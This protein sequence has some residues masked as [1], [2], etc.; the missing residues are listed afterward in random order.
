MSK[1]LPKGWAKAELGKVVSSQKGKK[2]KVLKTEP[3]KGAVPYLDIKAF[4]KNEV[5]KYAEVS[6]SRIIDESAVAMVW[7]GARSGWTA[8]GKYGALGSTLAAITPII[9]DVDYLFY[10]L[11]SQYEYINNNQRG[12][13]IPH[14]DPDKLW[15]LQFPLAPL[16]EQ[17]RI[18]DKLDA[19]FGHMDNINKGLERIPDLLKKFR[20]QV[21]TQAV[22]GKLTEDWRVENSGI[23]HVQHLISETNTKRANHYA[24]LVADAKRNKEKKP[25]KPSNLE[26]VKSLIDSPSIRIEDTTNEWGIVS[27]AWVSDNLPD[28]IVD[29]PF[30]SSINVKDDYIG[31]G[32][33]VVRMVNIRPFRFVKEQLRFIRLQ[34][35]LELRRHNILPTDVLLAKVGAT[36]GDCCIYPDQEPE[37][38]LSTTG[39]CRVRLDKNVMLPDFLQLYLSSK[40]YSLKIISSQTAQ[41]F[42]NMKTLK[43]FPVV[44]PFIEE[45]KEIVKRVDALFKVADIIEQQYQALHKKAEQLPQ[46]ILSKAFRGELVPQ[47]PDDEPATE[48]LKQ[49]E[50]MK[51]KSK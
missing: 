40:A 21:L 8:K 48:L 22:T 27:L 19:L 44:L 23:K 1:Q 15:S 6:T 9:G 4:E 50:T 30:G 51:N 14:V 28:S 11:Q 35:F 31:E 42:L 41:P 2:P 17:K 24:Q 47:Y 36:I 12:I 46:A 16:A 13:G 39:S 5:S 29:G 18:A 45:Q 43:A 7:D 26:D 20:Q 38:M 3:F 37:A 34:K 49:I 25:K 10:Y 32:V 33:P